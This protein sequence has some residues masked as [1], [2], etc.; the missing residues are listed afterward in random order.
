MLH[1]CSILRLR[2]DSERFYQLTREGILFPVFG[3]VP[4]AIA[5]QDE[6]LQRIVELRHRRGLS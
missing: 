2:I 3:N 6:R 5:R 1:A 4:N